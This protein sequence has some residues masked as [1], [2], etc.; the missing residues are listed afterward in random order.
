MK[1]LVW[2]L[3]ILALGMNAF[4]EIPEEWNRARILRGGYGERCGGPE[5]LDYWGTCEVKCGK[6]SKSGMAK[7]SVAITPFQGKKVTYR[8]VSVYVGD[9]YPIYV[10]WPS[11]YRI[12]LKDNGKF[13]GEPDYGTGARPCCDPDNIWDAQIGGNFQ[14][15]HT[16]SVE[17]YEWGVQPSD[18]FESLPYCMNTNL[19]QPFSGIG[20]YDSPQDFYVSG[21]RWDFGRSPTL[22]YVRDFSSQSI[23]PLYSLVGL[24]DPSQPNLARTKIT[25]SEKTGKFKGSFTVY[26]DPYVCSANW[27]VSV[28]KLRK[29]TVGVTGVVLNGEGIG[30]AIYKKV[31]ATWP[32]FVY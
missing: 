3:I 16:F 5:N 22:K 4:A 8:P 24:D 10:N 7:V 27:R 17:V 23:F 2:M 6:A 26:T 11:K 31:K 21:N 18:V 28:P 25:Y 32:V 13:S 30:L 9:G 14:G 29:T 20:W 15:W 12:W 1:A 19:A